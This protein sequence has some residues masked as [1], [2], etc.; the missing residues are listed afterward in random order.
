M[1]TALGK[2]CLASSV[3]PGDGLFLFE[4][5]QRARKCFV[6]E[7]ELHL[8]YLVTPFNSGSLTGHIDWMIFF[9][10]WK[11]LSESERRVGQMV[12]IEER[13]IMSAIRGIAKLGKQVIC[14]YRISAEYRSNNEFNF[15]FQQNIHRRF[16]TAL[17]LHD[18]V[19]EIPLTT[20]SEKYGCSRGVLQS[21]Q[22]SAS[23]F[24]GNHFLLLPSP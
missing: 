10:L 3:S 16:F 21:L 13:F 15:S 18:L 12:G 22:Q 4:E 19:R 20:V 2:A 24:A 23:T 5:L 9:N 1:A 6:L 14:N 8:I 7:T 11:S 17:A